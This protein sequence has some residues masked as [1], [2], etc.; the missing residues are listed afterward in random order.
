[1]DKIKKIKIQISITLAAMYVIIMGFRIISTA[2]QIRNEVFEACQED[3]QYTWQAAEY[4]S[5]YNYDK[6]K[7]LLSE[8]K[9]S[10][11]NYTGPSNYQAMAF[12]DYDGTL[13]YYEDPYVVASRLY[14]QILTGLG[15]TGFYG[16]VIDSSGK[17][18]V[19]SQDMILAERDNSL[20]NN[21]QSVYDYLEVSKVIVLK[22]I[23]SDEV[24]ESML[25][26]VGTKTIGSNYVVS[27]T[28]EGAVIYPSEIKLLN[29]GEVSNVYTAD[30]GNV[31]GT[32]VAEW[33]NNGHVQLDGL[34]VQN[35]ACY[36]AKSILEEN[37]DYGQVLE[38]GNVT[39]RSNNLFT[40]YYY[41]SWHIGDE[42][43]ANYSFV[44]HPLLLALSAMRTEL[45]WVAVLFVIA[46]VI[47]GI[48]IN[49]AK[50]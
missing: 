4:Y 45:I 32:D 15:T 19:E 12:R 39:E 27:G 46:S 28:Y 2:I 22:D 40:S 35:S 26:D 11:L 47:S 38:G 7:E 33:I 25:K 20:L 18:L 21:P 5:A 36:D 49:K 37:I 42:Y 13:W 6:A 3:S 50:N 31:E 29:S 16:N 14:S 23:F 30:E 41:G 34:T 44:F 17:V 43:A 8:Y 48:F 1:M 24:I 9:W 10:E